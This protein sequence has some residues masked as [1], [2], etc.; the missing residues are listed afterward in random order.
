M[1]QPGGAR[2]DNGASRLLRSRQGARGGRRLAAG[3]RLGLEAGRAS[4]GR[5]GTASSR[6]CIV[7]RRTSCR[8]AND[9]F[10]LDDPPNLLGRQGFVFEQPL[11]QR[12]QLVEPRSQDFTRRLLAF[13]DDAADL[14]V[15]YL[16]GGLGDVL[17]LG[18]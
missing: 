4:G 8:F 9:P 15:D 11:R 3:L 6:A 12:V 10:P 16:G 5:D 18:D 17:A 2:S 13:V 7:G 14:L 1:T